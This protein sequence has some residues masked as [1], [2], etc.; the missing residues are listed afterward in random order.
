MLPPTDTEEVEQL[1][2]ENE[3]LSTQ[4]LGWR[5]S[6]ADLAIQSGQLDRRVAELQAELERLRAEN[7]RLREYEKRWFL[8]LALN[9]A[10][11]EG[12][13]LKKSDPSERTNVEPWARR[14]CE[15]LKEALPLYGDL[16][17]CSGLLMSQRLHGLHPPRVT[18]EPRLRRAGS[19]Q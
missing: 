10:H 18:G 15:M 3:N 2:V 7:E 14:I 8:K 16:L 6:A 19:S 1:R 9:E 13:R 5:E 12:F 11:E 17:Y 4:E